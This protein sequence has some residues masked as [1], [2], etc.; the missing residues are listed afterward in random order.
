MMQKS[1][2]L[3]FTATVM[4]DVS[5]SLEAVGMNQSTYR[6]LVHLDIYLYVVTP[7]GRSSVGAQASYP[8]AEVVLLGDKR[9]KN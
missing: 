6:V 3:I 7:G 1:H 2:K 8:M 4:S 9:R 5:S